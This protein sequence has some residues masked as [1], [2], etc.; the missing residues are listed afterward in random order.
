MPFGL[1]SWGVRSGQ[2]TLGD[3]EQ[4]SECQDRLDRVA[5]SLTP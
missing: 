4:V 2:S 3:T 5:S 1:A